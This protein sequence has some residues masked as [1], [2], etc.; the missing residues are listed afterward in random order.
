MESVRR[1]PGFVDE[2]PP[3]RAGAPGLRTEGTVVAATG[4]GD[5]AEL[6]SLAAFL[7]TLGRPVERLTGRELRRL[8]PALGPD[9]RGG[10][11]VP[12]DLAV[13]NRVLLAA[14]ARRLREAPGCASCRRAARAS[15]SPTARGSLGVRCADGAEIVG[16]DR[17]SW[18][19]RARTPARCTP[20]CAGL[21]RPVK[22]EILRLAHA[23]RRFP[24]PP[25]TVRA[26]V[27]GRPVY[28]VPRDDG[29]LVLG[30]TQYEAGF[31]TTS[32]SAASATCCATP[33]ACCPRSPSTRWWR[34]PP[35]CAR[36]APTTGR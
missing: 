16:A 18:S 30:A 5:R 24:P 23:A 13:D 9:V 6:D 32:P 11:S 33:S 29:G 15:C 26:L 36:A 12:G 20:R 2:L 4:A 27:D 1:W 35:G 19:A 3:P 14:P 31:D 10:L 17:A 8:D 25:R 34:R 21:V 28:A 22:G 7:R